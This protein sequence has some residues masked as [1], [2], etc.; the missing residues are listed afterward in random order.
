MGLPPESTNV[1]KRR[2]SNVRTVINGT[3]ATIT[4]YYTGDT[5]L[6]VSIGIADGSGGDAEAGIGL[7][8]LAKNYA[9]G[10]ILSDY[11]LVTPYAS[12]TITVSYWNGTSWTVGETHNLSG[13]ITSPAAEFRDGNSGFGVPGSRIS[14]TAANL[15]SGANLWKFVGTQPFALI[16]NDSVDDEEVLAG[17]D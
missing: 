17:W 2:A 10:S 12:N 9:Y 1:Y 7:E 8:K 5:E 16:I 4:P 11:Q 15:G 6:C 13:T 3:P 14:G